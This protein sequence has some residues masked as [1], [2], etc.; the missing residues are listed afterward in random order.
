MAKRF[1]KYND[2]MKD[3]VDSVER[4]V[5]VF[6]RALNTEVK[7][8]TPVRTGRAQRGWRIVSQ[9]KL[10]KPGVIENRVPY[11]GLLEAGYS[12]Q[13]PNGMLGPALNRLTRR[14]YRI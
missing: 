8:L 6:L 5:N 12:K 11:I 7:R 9:Y 2:V 13:A 3:I 10:S 1:T 4:S 14:T